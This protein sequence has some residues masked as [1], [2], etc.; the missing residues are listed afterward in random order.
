MIP[1]PTATCVLQ[2]QNGRLSARLDAADTDTLDTL[3]GV[4]ADHLLRMARGEAL[5]ITWN[6]ID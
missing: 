3:E 5:S 1:F 4:V 6:R 2:V